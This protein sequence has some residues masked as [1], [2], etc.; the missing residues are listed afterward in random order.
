MKKKFGFIG[1]GK[2]GGAIISGII[3]SNFCQNTDIIASEASSETAQKRSL[4]LNIEVIT[5]NVTLAKQSDIIFIATKPN[6]VRD[7]LSQISPHISQNQLIVSIAAGITIDT[8]KEFI[9]NTVHIIRVMPNTPALLN[10]GM[11]GITSSSNTTKQELDTIYNLLSALG[12]CII[13]PESQMNVVTAISGSGPAFF[14]KVIHEIALAG[15]KLGMSYENALTLA[16]QT[17]LGSAKMI[18]TSEMSPVQLI[19][20]VATKGGC[21]QVGVD[22]MNTQNSEKFFFDV[23]QKTTQKAE[24]LGNK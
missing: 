7:V 22:F 11:F 24:A 23:I 12:K 19:D 6:M 5:D 14:Y 20:S 2:M 1:C 13:V 8:I 16:A 17:A 21:T 10:E 15:E 18:K 3:N 4:D 9:N